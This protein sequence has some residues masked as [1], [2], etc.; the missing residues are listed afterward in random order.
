MTWTR[1]DVS[2]SVTNLNLNLVVS[3]TSLQQTWLM[4]FTPWRTRKRPPFS[5]DPADA[6]TSMGL[7]DTPTSICCKV[8]DANTLLEFKIEPKMIICNLCSFNIPWRT[9]IFFSSYRNLN[10]LITTMQTTQTEKLNAIR[11][12]YV[13][14]TNFA[15]HWFPPCFG[16]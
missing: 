7:K 14:E 8:T 12:K 13:S 16:A 4:L 5:S 11:S 2:A 10:T 15:V 1:L 6:V 3:F 9:W